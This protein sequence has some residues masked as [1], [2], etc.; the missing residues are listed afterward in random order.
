MPLDDQAEEGET[1]EAQP[2]SMQRTWLIGRG[3]TI[4]ARHKLA[5]EYCWM[6]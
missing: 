1:S 4:D 5:Q 6:Q 3:V 2:S